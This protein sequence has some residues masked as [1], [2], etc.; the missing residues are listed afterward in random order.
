[1]RTTTPVPTTMMTT[2]TMTMRTTTPVPTTMMTAT[3]TTTKTTTTTR[4]PSTTPGSFDVA[5]SV[6]PT[7]E[8]KSGISTATPHAVEASASMDALSK[9]SVLC[10][11]LFCLASYSCYCF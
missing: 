3:A 2:T 6:R 5:D 10:A 1:M 4:T 11:C 9:A 8:T 7:L